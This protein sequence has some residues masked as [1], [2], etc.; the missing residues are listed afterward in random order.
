MIKIVFHIILLEMLKL[1][2]VAPS[3]YCY[4]TAISRYGHLY[5]TAT[6]ILCTDRQLPSLSITDTLEFSAHSLWQ[7]MQEIAF[8][9]NRNLN[10]FL[11]V[12]ISQEGGR[13]SNVFRFRF[14]FNVIG[15]ADVISSAEQPQDQLLLRCHYTRKK[16]S[17]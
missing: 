3:K 2:I 14:M 6:F 16:N 10:Y 12:H 11:Y 4:T 15:S 5:D 7:K 17:K 8:F 13:I 1:I 9:Y